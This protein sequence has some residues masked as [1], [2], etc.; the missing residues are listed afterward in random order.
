MDSG[1]SLTASAE[2]DEA[3]AAF[4]INGRTRDFRKKQVNHWAARMP[5]EG[6]WIELAW[7]RPRRIR[8]IQITFDSG[9]RRE[10]TLSAAATGRRAARGL[11]WAFA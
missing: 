9:F 5:P 3:K 11:S 6:V 10:L 1:R 4:V 8:E 7:D 2:R